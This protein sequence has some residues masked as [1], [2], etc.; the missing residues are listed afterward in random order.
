[1]GETSKARGRREREGW[2]AEHIRL[3]GLDIGGGAD[4]IGLGLVV[5]DKFNGQE[6]QSLEGIPPVS[7][8][9]IYS[10][11]VL[12]HIPDPVMAVRSWWKALAPGG[13]MIVIVPHRD[14]YEKKKTPPSQWNMEHVTFW[15]PEED[16]LPGT[17]SLSRVLE[18]A[19]PDAKRL[20]LR[21]IDDGFNYT[22]PAYVHSVGEYSIEAILEKPL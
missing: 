18:E 20:S 15:L 2:F 8:Q 10:S 1:M 13:R 17:F 16:E 12:E 7:Q 11:H 14:L 9:T 4:S 19:C 5:Y 6:A 3:P 21:V 22:L